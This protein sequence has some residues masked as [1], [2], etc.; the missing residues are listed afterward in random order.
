MSAGLGL[1]ARTIRGM[2]WAYG[3]YVGGRLLVL[4]S[5]AVLARLLTP[6]DFGVVALAVVILTFLDTIRDL[7]LGQALIARGRDGEEEARAQTV[8]SWTVVIGAVLAVALAALGPVAAA[9]FDVA[10]LR[11][12]LPALAVNFFLQSLGATHDA[13]ARKALNYRVRTIAEVS[14]AGLR[15][16]AGIVLALLGFGAWS[17]IL[18]YLIG[19]LVRTSL[20]WA[21]VPFR[22]KLRLSRA[23]LRDL[24]QFGGVLTVVDIGA[25][26]VQEI[27]Y[28]FVGR[29][30]GATALGTYVLGYRLPE[31]L[32][33]NLAIVAGD[34]LFPAYAALD[35]G[36][37]REGFLLSLRSTAL[38][39]F[40]MAVGVAVLARPIILGL[41]G[42]QWESSITVMQVLAAYAVV[43]TLNIPSGMVYKV[44]GRAWI[45]VATTVPYLVLLCVL[46]AILTERGILAVALVM[47]GC[48]A[49]WLLI[50]FAIIRRVLD[51]PF[52]QIARAVAGPGAAAAGMGLV[53]LPIPRLI[54]APWPA[55]LLGA[56]AG[57][58]AYAILVW[59]LARDV[60]LRLRDTAFARVSVPGGP[61]EPQA[62]G[63]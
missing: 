52:G 42:D 47:A 17:L 5:M 54:E 36:R 27:D 39:T 19:M 45:L 55:L 51:V 43:I 37:L 40:P 53:L 58:L 3:S 24:M 21:L 34:V 25:A 38:I 30:L 23:H 8:F 2:L 14:D 46:L 63:A 28:V 32:I 15:G 13:L 9:F 31:L 62:P 20:L 48:Q 29:I 18:G 57:A 35:R 33:L 59:M 61:A 50:D 56:V 49:G 41:F 12:I 44:T 1:G 22:P 4:A 16:I 26:I 6:G 7:G 60:V 11:G 10:A